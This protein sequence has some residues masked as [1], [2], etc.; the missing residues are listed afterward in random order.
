M[1]VGVSLAT[2]CKGTP[3][4]MAPEVSLS[5]LA[6]LVGLDVNVDECT[7]EALIPVFLHLYH[8]LP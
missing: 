1:Q 7:Y 4:F 5:V 3:Y 6:D 2:S 8:Q